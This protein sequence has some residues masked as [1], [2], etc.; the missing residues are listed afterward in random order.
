MDAPDH[1]IHGG[2]VRLRKDEQA[3]KIICQ[4]LT[5]ISFLAYKPNLF[6]SLS[7]LLVPGFTTGPVPRE[8]STTIETKKITVTIDSSNQARNLRA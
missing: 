1:L 2:F 4:K 3:V 7:F 5:F 8:I 6:Q